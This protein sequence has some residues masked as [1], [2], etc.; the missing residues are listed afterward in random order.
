MSRRSIVAIATLLLFVIFIL[1]LQTPLMSAARS[2]TWDVFTATVAK[3]FRIRGFQIDQSALDHIEQLRA[4]NARLKAEVRQSRITSEQLGTPKVENMHAVP[5]AVVSRPLDTLKSQYVISK[6]IQ[7]GITVGSPVVIQGSI[8]VGFIQTVN[9]NSAVIQTL[10]HPST[11]LTVETVPEDSEKPVARG[12]LQSRYYTS[13]H[14]TTIP[15]DVE[16]KEGEPIV[17]SI[18]EANLPQGMLIGTI[19]S[20]WNPEHEAYQEA[21]ILMP[22]D[23]DQIDAVYVLVAP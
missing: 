10:Y 5:A 4:E 2:K 19:E 17:T 23:I 7:D 11:H 3:T 16:I 18:K 21:R 15:R 6:G 1:F 14:I 12:L 22:Y 8:L 13:L 9:E 20:I